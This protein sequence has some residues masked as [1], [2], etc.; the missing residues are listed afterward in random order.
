MKTDT[1]FK[2]KKTHIQILYKPR[3]GNTELDKETNKKQG[4]L[5]WGEKCSI[6]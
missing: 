1:S 2:K 6:Y 4:W 3:V 5:L